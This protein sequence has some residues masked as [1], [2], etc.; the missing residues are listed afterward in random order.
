MDEKDQQIA[1][2]RIVARNQKLAESPRIS[3]SL[4]TPGGFHRFVLIR[5]VVLNLIAYKGMY[6]F[7]KRTQIPLRTASKPMIMRSKKAL[8]CLV[9]VATSFLMAPLSR[10]QNGRA[11]ADSPTDWQSGSETLM[12]AATES[13]DLD[14]SGLGSSPQ[15]SQPPE[16]Y[17]G[18]WFARVDK[19]QAEQPH[20]ITPVATTTPRLEEEFRY[21]IGWQHSANGTIGENY[22][23]SK[24]LELIPAERV[25]IIVSPPPYIVH[26]QAGEE[27][28]FGDVS[29]L[30][31]YRVLAGNEQH[32]NYILTLFLAATAPT[33]Q[34]KNGA[35][36]AT[37]TPTVAAGK[38]FGHFDVQSTFG[39]TLPIGDTDLIGRTLTWNTAFQYRI[40]RIFWPEVE[41][42]SSFFVD[43][44]NDGKK[45]TFLTPGIV[46]GR[47]HLWHRLSLTI[48][49]GYQIAATQFHKNNHNGILSVRF[50]F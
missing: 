4:W 35:L 24:G 23:L 2:F 39:E 27:D 17:W 45:Q 42:N 8:P 34:A 21:D 22:G 9:V 15:S 29:F 32:G 10:A 6:C 19:T 26:S 44:P 13:G 11:G 40:R 37:V 41:V 38:G 30:L 18:K 46:V 12:A 50:P 14:G 20:W 25:E 48:G 36:D 31:K 16:G 3:N 7:G 43:G 5:L 28:G 1:H 47:I 33:G 49:G